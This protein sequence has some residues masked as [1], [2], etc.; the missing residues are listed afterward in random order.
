MPVIYML[1]FENPWALAGLLIAVETVFVVFWARHRTAAWAWAVWIVL[2]ISPAALTL[3]ELFETP[4]ER[5]VAFCWELAHAI[6]EGELA[7]IAAHIAE[8][9]QTDGLDRPAFVQRLEQTLT[10]FRVDH[11]RLRDFEVTFPTDRSAVAVLTATCLVRSI[12][13][14]FDHLPSRWRLTLRRDGDSW[15]VVGIESIPIPPLNVRDLR[16]WLR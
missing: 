16:D 14:V 3:S 4:R 13:A 7:P 2:A 5:V 12:D 10:R 11:P 9:F 15:Q 6:D 8:D 1:L